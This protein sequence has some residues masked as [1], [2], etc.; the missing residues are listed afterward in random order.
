MSD[1][2]RRL[3]VV[4]GINQYKNGIATLRNPLNDAD[5]IHHV[6]QQQHNYETHLLKDAN[7]TKEQI[8]KLLTK[9]LPKQVKEDECLLFYFAGH[10]IALDGDDGPQGYLI[11][12]DAVAGNSSTYLPM[13]QVH[14]WLTAL[15]CRHFLTILD[16]CF[17][18]AFRW[19][20]TRD[21]ATAPEEIYLE[22]YHRFIEHPAWQV[23][24]SASYDETALDALSS[25][26]K[27]TRS[28]NG[29]HSP[30]A[31]ALI[32]A[33]TGGADTTPPAQN[34]KPAGDGV[35]TATE[36]Y[37]YLRDRVETA[38][39]EAEKR[40]TPGLWHLKN[41][42]RG[43]YIF[44]TPGHKL[45]LKNAPPLD[46]STNPYRGL[47]S[48]RE[49][50][51]Q[52]FFGRTTLVEKL[53][54]FVESNCLSVV[55][56]ASGSGK[57]SLVKAGLIPQLRKN[58]QSWKILKPIRPGASPFP[59]LNNALKQAK[60]PKVEVVDT[61][62][63]QSR[64]NLNQSMKIWKTKNPGS[65]LL[66]LIDQSEELITLCKDES[67]RQAFV[68]QLL[69]AMTTHSDE[70]RV[71]ITVRSDFEPQLRDL[72][73]KLRPKLEDTWQIGR[74][75]VP[76]MTR[77]ELREVIE[78][79]AEA[80]VMYF[81]PQELVEQLI[82]EVADMPGGLPLL[83]FALS[84]L[85]LK[86][87]Q[88][89]TK[90]QNQG[91]ILDRSITEADY[92]S[93]GGVTQSLTQRADEE[94]EGLVHQDSSYAKII[95]HVMLRMV[96]IGGGELA[97]RR[98]LLSELEYSQQKNIFVKEVIK[99]FTE[100][101]LLVRGKD[102]DGNSYV[103]PAHDAL[104]RGWQKLLVWK[105]EDEESLILQRRLTPAAQE[106]ESQQQVRF[107]WHNNPRLDLLKKVSQSD[108]NWLNNVEA[109]FV[110][111]SV[112][113]KRTNTIVRWS[114]AGS[115]LL[116][117]MIFSAA[118]W[119]Q[120]RK[121]ELNQANAL[122]RY[123]LYLFAEHKKM[124]A[125][126][127]A[128]RA[129]KIIQKHNARDPQVI[130]ALQKVIYEGRERNR[131]QGHDS[132]VNSVS[133][134]P[135]GQILAS[136]SGDSTIKLWN[137][138]TGEEI[139]TLRGHDYSV[140]IVSFSPDG[141]TL[142][143]G[144]TDKTIKLWNLE[145]GEEIGTLQ[146]HTKWLNSLS[147]S[148]DGQTLAFDS[149]DRTIKLWN[150]KTGK[151]RTLQGH[152]SSV[153]SLSFSPDGQTLASGSY[154]K[155]IKLWNL[156]T[157]EVRTLQGHDYSVD[158]V[159][160]SPDGQTLASG[161]RDKTIKLWNLETGKVIR[162]LQGHTS[163]VTSVSFSPDGQTLAS[164]SWDNT[165]KL[166]NLET[167]W[168]IRTLQGH[169]SMVTSVSF[170]PDGQTLASASYDKTIKLWDPTEE[171]I[172][173][174]QGHTRIVNSVSFSPDGQTLASGSS[175]NTIKLW[176]LETGEE[177]RTLQGH[178][179]IVNSVSFSPD[180]QTL[181]SGSFDSTIKL[182]NL[183]TGEVIHTLQGHDSSVDSVSISPDG[184][185]LASGSR[186]KTIKLWNLETG[187]EIRTLQGHTKWVE[188][189]S[190]SPDSQTLASGS[191]DK[192]IKLWNLETGEEIPTLKRH[193]NDVKRVSFSPDGQ[194]LASGS[195]DNTI[196]F[197]NLETGEEI[198]TLQGPTGLVNS[199]SFSPNHQTLASQ[200]TGG[201]LKL[202]Y[203]KAGNEVLTL[204]EHDPFPGERE[205]YSVNSI[206]ISPDSQTL[207]TVSN[208]NTIKL[209]NIDLDLDSLMA[210]SCGWGRN[211]LQN[212]PNV[213]ESDRRLCD[214]VPEPK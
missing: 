178:T 200:S 22:H 171:V 151:V 113:K 13:N 198:R 176:N 52:L 172:R 214:G 167:G 157:G 27:D 17:A 37:S 75:I 124:E 60:L 56:G 18:G 26:Q 36:L 49:K 79:P 8:T 39:I 136:G 90:A 1:F 150:L 190:F 125:F 142:A 43:E 101:R 189:V 206:S 139:H 204:H 97:R 148:P 3:A 158:S 74:F 130:T 38:T 85:Y 163:M 152:D 45:N 205:G 6:L 4:I 173:T 91:K 7:A 82:D 174:L 42:D 29:N 104:V 68:S 69:D 63:A 93:I 21:F 53:Y 71:V 196:K 73:L 58:Q 207:A 5:Q 164:G 199:V 177:I 11:P 20:S 92:E 19:S 211:Y 134:S 209:W 100:A 181:A 84:E 59:E 55:L 66:L 121:S 212:N 126:V 50:D 210:R 147:F 213:K 16:C 127:E 30:F 154:D 98:V 202:W 203:F 77:A 96:A 119:M 133:F 191:R 41:H 31:A 186:D 67:E 118:V 162:T 137:L 9:T 70:L 122:A 28:T 165:I 61:T 34:G 78:K 35:I 183:E 160:F 146:T 47:E 149:R 168:G 33:L 182:W 135:D 12:Q 81:E 112:R 175:D 32:D 184:Q 25:L 166:W 24:T 161:S 64:N 159:S 131:L 129:G 114:I 15:P 116:G 144:S 107:L 44:L 46:E 14:D 110:E 115:V 95:R 138:E 80:R 109:E 102:G 140:E 194:T 141:Q 155:T 153:N 72:F 123:S 156:E 201:T 2:S 187:E 87:L 86:Y 180:G 54:D 51:T 10:G 192:T 145:T 65:K 105:Q 117:A 108:N 197:W 48:F 185:T 128:S 23:I 132:L 195:D 170:S 62:S 76:Q 40:Q 111:R 57:S 89:Q 94:Y 99:S 120:W 169:T 179:R 106:W 83:S 193:N 208:D 188:S 143:S 88:R 103:E